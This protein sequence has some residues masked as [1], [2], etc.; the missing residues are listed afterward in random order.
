MAQGWAA[1][2]VGTS[3]YLHNLPARPYTLFLHLHRLDEWVASEMLLAKETRACQ[4]DGPPF[5]WEVSVVVEFTK[6]HL[7]PSVVRHTQLSARPPDL[8][9][10]RPSRRGIVGFAHWSC[11]DYS[12]HKRP[13][14]VCSE[15]TRGPDA[16]P[17]SAE[18]ALAAGLALPVLAV[19]VRTDRIAALLSAI[20]G[21]RMA[22]SLLRTP[23]LL[24]GGSW[25]SP[26]PCLQMDTWRLWAEA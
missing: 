8:A 1:L 22:D 16:L 2:F 17:R 21:A 3:C 19:L 26:L 23:D 7:L 10:I 9:L 20:R 14:F 5:G 13:N 25:N 11:D 4:L 6:A 24:E 18:Q 12:T 15:P